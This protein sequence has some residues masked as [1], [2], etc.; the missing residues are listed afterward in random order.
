MLRASELS[1]D[2]W[3]PTNKN[4]H[5]RKKHCPFLPHSWIL[6]C[7]T[8][9]RKNAAQALKISRISK[10]LKKLLTYTL[11]LLQN[12]SHQQ[13]HY[14]SNNMESVHWM[15]RFQYCS[16]HELGWTCFWNKWIINYHLQLHLFSNGFK[17][18]KNNNILRFLNFW[19]SQ[20]PLD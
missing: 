16:T 10:F 8:V 17:K 7:W 1:G 11:Q 9:R 13:P 12:D 4:L 15:K 5:D 3:N 19:A 14:K 2:I 18:N 20:N 6:L